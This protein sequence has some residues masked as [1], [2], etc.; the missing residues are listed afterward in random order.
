M[1]DPPAHVQR[2]LAIIDEEQIMDE[3][4]E[5]ASSLSDDDLIDRALARMEREEFDSFGFL[6][7]VGFV[8]P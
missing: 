6:L 7:L 2:I 5:A 8:S 4:R 3:E 1:T